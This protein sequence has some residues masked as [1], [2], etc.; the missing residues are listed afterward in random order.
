[1]VGSRIASVEAAIA[2]RADAINANFAQTIAVAAREVAPSAPAMAAMRCAEMRRC[3][4]M[5]RADVRYA[6]RGFT[7]IEV[8]VAL[9][10]IAVALAASLRAVGSLASG[11][12]EL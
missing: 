2:A 10:I 3:S 7:M 6:Q 12:A 1:M 8:L 5:V 4:R 11:E 9:A